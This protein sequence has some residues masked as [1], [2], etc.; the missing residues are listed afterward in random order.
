MLGILVHA[1]I[2][3]VVVVVVVVVVVYN[4]INAIALLTFGQ[5]MTSLN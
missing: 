5:L 1:V 3:I 2:V 4:K